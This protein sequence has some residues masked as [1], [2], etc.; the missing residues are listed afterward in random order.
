MCAKESSVY[1]VQHRLSLCNQHY[2]DW[3]LRRAEE[4]I[5]KYNM[6]NKKDKILVAISGGKDSIALWDVLTTLGYKSDGLYINLGITG[7]SD[8]SEEVSKT[9]AQEKGLKLHI[10]YLE[11]EFASI[12]QIKKI[13]RRPPCSFCGQLKRYYMNKFAKDM[14]Y[15]VLTTGHN[16]DDE[17]S[18]LLLNVLNW[19]I[20]YLTR[21]S[22][23]LNEGNGFVKKVK[24]LFKFTAE[25]NQFY[26]SLKGLKY[27]DKRCPY[28]KGA[29]SIEYKR[30]LNE[31]EKQ[32]PSTKLRF[33]LD[34]IKKLK[35]LL[36]IP[37]PLLD[38]C[39]N[40]GQPTTVT[41]CSICRLKQ[42]F[43]S[44]YQTVSNS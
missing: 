32:S 25:E 16:L 11:K 31:I 36:H 38:P 2:I 24:P 9:Y 6:F 42:K 39:K 26:V 28:S 20:E 15:T 7:F 18:T 22:P 13:E 12:P 17:A 10:V 5:R 14:G 8:D 3:Y 1:L 4:T 35:P 40:C 44:S 43:I 19:N 33:Y 29:S 41:I 30:I 23:V 37:Q 34:F 27:V 21:Q